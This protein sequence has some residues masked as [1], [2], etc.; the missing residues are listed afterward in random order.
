MGHVAGLRIIHVQRV[1]R[2][3][4]GVVEKGSH[5]AKSPQFPAIFVANAIV[6]IVGTLTGVEERPFRNS[7]QEFTGHCPKGAIR[8]MGNPFQDRP[9]IVLC[10]RPWHVVSASKRRLFADRD[11]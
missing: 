1:G 4:V 7:R 11:A 10:Q 5:H 2:L 8:L 9:N 6:G 3:G